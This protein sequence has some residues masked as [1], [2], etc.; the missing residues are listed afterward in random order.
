[1]RPAAER[2]A[3]AWLLTRMNDSDWSLNVNRTLP[4]P[5]QGILRRLHREHDGFAW[6]HCSGGACP[7]QLS[8]SAYSHVEKVF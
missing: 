5:R 3:T 4:A 6:S 2:F 1:M 7:G 8:S